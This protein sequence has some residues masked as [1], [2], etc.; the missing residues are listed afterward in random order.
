MIKTV[1]EHLSS[2]TPVDEV[3]FVVG[4]SRVLGK[5]MDAHALLTAV[6]E[7]GRRQEI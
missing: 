7:I 6:R 5:P 3:L 2:D 4:D 1:E